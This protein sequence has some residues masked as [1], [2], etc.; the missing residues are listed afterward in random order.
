VACH[1]GLPDVDVVVLGYPNGGYPGTVGRFELCCVSFR[2][3]S[4]AGH[5]NA[6]LSKKKSEE[7]IFAE[8]MTYWR[9][10][11]PARRRRGPRHP[12]RRRILLGPTLLGNGTASFRMAL[13]VVL[14]QAA[15]ATQSAT[16]ARCSSQ[17]LSGAAVYSQPKHR[18]P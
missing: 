10:N 2:L 3:V 1:T 17:C 13:D 11:R 12:P 8:Q 16:L 9:G 15:T 5:K 18:V 14:G 7:I 4:G 6:F